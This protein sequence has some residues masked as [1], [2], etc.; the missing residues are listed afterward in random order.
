M[1]FVAF[2]PWKVMELAELR[3]RK[4]S[5]GVRLAA[6]GSSKSDWTCWE[7]DINPLLTYLV[8]DR[9]EAP[10]LPKF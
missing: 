5:S 3:P 10:D 8:L 1:L 9:F 7:L 2:R 4:S 6:A